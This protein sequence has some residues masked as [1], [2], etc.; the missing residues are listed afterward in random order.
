M[1]T[2]LA[3]VLLLA[4]AC[5]GA[6][7]APP[8]AGTSTSATATATATAPGSGEATIELVETPPVETTLDHPDVANAS[9]TWVAMIDRARRSV[10]FAEFYASEAE[11]KDI[12]QSQLTPVIAAIERAVKRGVKVRFLADTVFAPKYPETLQTLRTIGATVRIIDFGK[13]GGGILHA[14]YFVVDG[15]ESFVGSQN[16][17]WRALG[18]IQEIGVR[19]TS[20]VIAAE[21]L[22]LLD[23]DWELAAGAAADTRVHHAR[24]ADVQARTGELLTLTAT[25]KGWLPDESTWELPKLVALLDGAKRAIDVQVLEYKTK[26]RDGSPFPTLDDALRRAAARGVHVR[27][28]VSDWSTKP[29]SDARRVLDDL[30]KEPNVE[31]RVITIPKYSGG[32]IPFARVAHAKYMVVDGAAGASAHAWVGTSNWE[33]DYFTKS[34]NVGVIVTGGKL[35]ARL[36]GIFE[37][38]WSGAYGKPLASVSPSG[39]AAPPS[40]SG[41]ARP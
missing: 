28:L 11:P 29:G 24:T 3:L 14:K 33:G 38:G 41:P 2:R 10:D 8:N 18:H 27:L 13:R 1:K 39:S 40:S 5:G 6:P 19:V 35:P 23:T 21:L 17:D 36:D 22:D 34:R 25:P 15:A 37:D 16:F 32:E 4:T 9:P 30:A 26:E 31:V 7:T 20:P 12:A